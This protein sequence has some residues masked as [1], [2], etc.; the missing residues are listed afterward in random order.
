MTLNPSPGCKGSSPRISPSGTS[1]RIVR[2]SWPVLTNIEGSCRLHATASISQHALEIPSILLILSDLGQ[3][4]K[5]TGVLM[6]QFSVLATFLL[7]LTH[8]LFPGL[9]YTALAISPDVFPQF[10]VF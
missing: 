8:F 9:T 3:Q 6:G 1:H 4:R 10:E 5:E 2:R 7:F